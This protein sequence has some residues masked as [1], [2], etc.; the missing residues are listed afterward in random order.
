MKYLTLFILLMLSLSAHA[1]KQETASTLRS[2]Y[3]KAIKAAKSEGARCM[4]AKD[5][6]YNNKSSVCT[7]R[8]QKVIVREK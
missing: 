1:T 4:P 7:L 6:R 2:D 3:N 8:S 5:S